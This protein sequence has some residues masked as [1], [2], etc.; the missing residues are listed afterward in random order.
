MKRERPEEDNTKKIRDTFRPPIGLHFRNGA[1]MLAYA[2]VRRGES[3]TG[4]RCE[5]LVCHRSHA[6]D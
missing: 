2:P 3:K 5:H 6:P 1:D 4:Y